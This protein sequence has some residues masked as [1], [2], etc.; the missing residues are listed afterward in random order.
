MWGLAPSTSPQDVPM[1]ITPV[2]EEAM[3]A[4]VRLVWL[5]AAFA[6]V[7]PGAAEGQVRTWYG[8]FGA[9][10][11]LPVGNLGDESDVGFH[12]MGSVGLNSG[13]LPVG[14]RADFFF[15]QFN[16]VEREPSVYSVLGGEWFRQFGGTVSAKYGLD[17]GSTRPYILAGGGWNHNWHADR[18][19]WP[20][21]QNIVSFNA[22]VG[23]D[24]NVFG[25]DWFIEA[26]H[27]NLFGG[28]PL[29]TR[30]PTIHREIPFKSIPVTFGVRF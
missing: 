7:L 14:L 5:L 8:A 17:M 15:Q 28:E 21:R 23:L 2:R 20:E 16:A 12:L 22:G 3:K 26:R 9:G 24:L 6:M 19:Y 27:L 11:T 30:P 10:P 13:A 4:K 25:A 1:V 29:E 18:T